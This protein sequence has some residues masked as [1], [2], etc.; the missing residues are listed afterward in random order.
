MRGHQQGL[1]TTHQ[2][3]LNME[4]ILEQAKK[5]SN[6]ENSMLTEA[7]LKAE[8]ERDYW[9]ARFENGK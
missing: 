1:R 4:T 9:K 8:E 5:D 2:S 6:W 7:L 3:L